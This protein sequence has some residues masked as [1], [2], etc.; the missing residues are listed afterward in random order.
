LVDVE[1]LGV[2]KLHGKNLQGHNG[3]KWLEERIGQGRNNAKAYLDEHPEMAKEIEILEDNLM[4]AELKL[5]E[6]L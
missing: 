3:E 1:A 4:G 6:Q 2:S 5:Q